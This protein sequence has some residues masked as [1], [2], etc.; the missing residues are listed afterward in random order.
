MFKR[1]AVS[2]ATRGK[3]PPPVHSLT[4]VPSGKIIVAV[5]QAS[6]WHGGGVGVEVDDCA[7]AT[8]ITAQLKLTRNASRVK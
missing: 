8:E 4:H 6:G 2:V 5:G 7:E 1:S 3:G